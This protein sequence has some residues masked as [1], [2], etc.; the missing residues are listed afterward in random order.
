VASSG[1][2]ANSVDIVYAVT[3]VP[4]IRSDGVGM[5]HLFLSSE[6]RS[7][8]SA[9]CLATGGDDTPRLAAA[10]LLAVHGERLRAEYIRA[11]CR[12]TAGVDETLVSSTSLPEDAEFVP[13]AGWVPQGELLYFW[14]GG[15]VSRVHGPLDAVRREL[16]CLMLREPLYQTPHACPVASVSDRAPYRIDREDG[17][18]HWTWGHESA[19]GE[20]SADELSGPMLPP[21]VFDLLPWPPIFDSRHAAT[22]ALSSALLSEAHGRFAEFE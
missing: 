10:D 11:C 1:S 19:E 20:P 22:V 8:M 5:T 4:G 12:R 13:L 17:E 18:E 16:P 14:Q 6:W 7:T 15:F 9:I 21:E 3:T 2:A